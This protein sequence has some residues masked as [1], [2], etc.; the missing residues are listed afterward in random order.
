MKRKKQKPTL[1]PLPSR[2][3][4][5]ISSA[6]QRFF[7]FFF[8][9]F[10]F[11]FFFFVLV[12]CERKSPRCGGLGRA[13][14]A[15]VANAVRWSTRTQLDPQLACFV[16]PKRTSETTTLFG[17]LEQPDVSNQHCPN[18]TK[19]LKKKTCMSTTC[20]LASTTASHFHIPRIGFRTHLRPP[21]EGILFRRACL[22]KKT[23]WNRSTM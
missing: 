19:K 20:S 21:H 11:F 14:E 12:L 3:A 5:N 6:T 15:L 23:R 17:Q 1:E 8:S 2:H 16:D 13:K 4:L 22:E 10:F 9:F 18:T 7:F